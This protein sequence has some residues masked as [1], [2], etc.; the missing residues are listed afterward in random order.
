[1]A[2]DRQWRE[3]AAARTARN[4]V[5]LP[6]IRVKVR[7]FFI[8]IIPAGEIWSSLFAASVF[9]AATY[10]LFISPMGHS[11]IFHAG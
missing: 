11:L 1:V 8:H 10:L 5:I 3:Y 9:K 4:S 7:V 6:G 2:L